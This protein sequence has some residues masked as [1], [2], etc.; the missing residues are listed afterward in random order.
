MPL[1]IDFPWPQYRYPRLNLV[2]EGK[3]G[4]LWQR[5]Q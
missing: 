4:E 2:N 3:E 1:Q 5:F